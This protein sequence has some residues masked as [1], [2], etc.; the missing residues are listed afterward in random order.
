MLARTGF[1]DPSPKARGRPMQCPLPARV[2]GQTYSTSAPPFYPPISHTALIR[3]PCFSPPEHVDP[4]HIPGS[5]ILSP[6]I[7]QSPYP[8]YLFLTPTIMTE[9]V[10]DPNHIPG[11][12]ILSPYIPQ[13]PYPSSLFLTP[14]IM[15]E[16]VDPNHIP[17]ST[18]LSPY[19]PH[20]PYPS[21]LFLTPRACRP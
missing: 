18:I 1:H 3:P 5:T 9:H 13:S 17:G 19:T 6:Y 12:T 16:H 2:K 4:N 11:S 21:S 14:T 8:S 7:P 20:S 15:I 10:V